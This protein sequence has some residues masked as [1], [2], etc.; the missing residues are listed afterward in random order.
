M[1]RKPR[2]TRFR[3]G[4]T[5][6]VA[7]FGRF[8]SRTRDNR[9]PSSISPARTSLRA[10]ISGGFA[11]R[12]SAVLTSAADEG[13]FAGSLANM[14]STIE[15]TLDGIAL[16]SVLMESGLELSTRLTVAM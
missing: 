4:T 5:L 14:L 12:I 11:V 6:G 3:S 7:A 2:T 1:A 8:V 9:R 16:V 13:R 10:L 15:A